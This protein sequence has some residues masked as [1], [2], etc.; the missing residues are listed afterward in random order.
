MFT[1]GGVCAPTI[2]VCRGLTEAAAAIAA[3]AGLAIPDVL[4]ESVWHRASGAYRPMARMQAGAAA[5]RAIRRFRKSC[6]SIAE[7][8]ES[9]VPRSLVRIG[10]LE[11]HVEGLEQ[12]PLGVFEREPGVHQIDVGLHLLALR[13]DQRIFVLEQIV[14]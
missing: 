12:R 10:D 8:S 4:A 2:Q 7:I 1:T 5:R 11:P 14:R 13:R 6:S 3:E 9:R